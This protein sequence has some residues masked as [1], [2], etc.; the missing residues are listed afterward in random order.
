MTT[1]Y[2]R[3][4]TEKREGV[5]LLTKDILNNQYKTGLHCWKSKL[6]KIPEKEDTLSAAY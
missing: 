1:T 3:K 6:G 2:K 5:L 4:L